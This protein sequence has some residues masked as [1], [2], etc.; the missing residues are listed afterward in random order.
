MDGPLDDHRCYRGMGS[1]CA[2][3]EGMGERLGDRWVSVFIKM[4]IA[5]AFDRYFQS[6]GQHRDLIP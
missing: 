3:T 1:L 2:W 4:G 5:V 6:D